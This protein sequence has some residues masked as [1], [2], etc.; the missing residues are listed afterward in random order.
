MAPGE[1]DRSHPVGNH[2]VL[3]IAP[4]RYVLLAHLRAGSLRVKPGDQ[5]VCGQPLA[6]CGNSGNTS[7]P[8]VHMQVQDGPEYT[9]DVRTFP[10][11]FRHVVRGG[12][13]ASAPITVRRND[14]LAPGGRCGG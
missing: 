6:E 7:E 8:H 9:D 11:E 2:V 4:R 10:I 13:P 12:V 5:V 14:H 3:E 1:Y